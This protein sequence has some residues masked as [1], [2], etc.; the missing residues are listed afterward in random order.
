MEMQARC[1]RLTPGKTKAR[2]TLSVQ[3]AAAF[4]Q[5]HQW[6]Q[7]YPDLPLSS[8]SVVDLT[9]VRTPSTSAIGK[10]T[11][12][13]QTQPKVCMPSALSWSSPAGLCP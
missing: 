10:V 2:L 12:L 5:W 3:R 9:Q 4:Q 13:K 7:E 6:Q 11:S 8:A 1:L